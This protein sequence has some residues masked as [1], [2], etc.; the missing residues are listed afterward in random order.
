VTTIGA[1]A[2]GLARIIVAAPG[3]RMEVAVPEQP[4]LR[5]VVP[6]LIEQ[7][8]RG[9]GGTT[10]AAGWTVRRTDGTVLDLGLSL[11]RHVV[12][13][14]EVVH[15]VPPGVSWPEPHHEDVIRLDTGAG[16]GWAPAMTWGTGLVAALLVLV[17]VP[18]SVLSGAGWSAIG[19]G[20]IAVA[21]LLVG[22]GI[23]I[24]RRD[25]PAQGAGMAAVG[26]VYGS[27]GG[28]LVLGGNGSV[29]AL[30]APHVLVA[31]Q[32][33]LLLSVAGYFGVVRFGRLFG[34][35]ILAGLAGTGSAVVALTPLTGAQSAAIAVAGVLIVMPALPLLSVRMAKVPT[36]AVPRGA[37]EMLTAADPARQQAVPGRVATT[38]DLLTG[39]LI[40]SGAVVAGAVAVLAHSG[41]GSALW[42][43]AAGTACL[44]LR[45]RL[46]LTR[47]HRLA[48][49]GAGGFGAVGLAVGLV[50]VAPA[51]VRLGVLLPGL[52]LVGLVCAAAGLRYSAVRPS[53]YL[54]RWAAALDVALTLASAPLAASV[55]GLYHVMRG[56][57]G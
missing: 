19:G 6:A 18:L 53:P 16:A 54:G 35:G 30:G 26:A 4:P 11:A 14:G 32:V 9:T 47:R 41:G 33:L 55:L 25:R 2:T 1:P 23:A 20:A 21:L 39:G 3:R 31:S 24:S 48:L 7:A 8:L 46:F 37:G 40:G 51:G 34:A 5:S 17:A 29:A 13:D 43:A 45:A 36:P 52:I 22:A 44:L 27:A 12:R 49:L 10:D 28:L 42:L 15:L 50:R 57:G 56:L 38:T